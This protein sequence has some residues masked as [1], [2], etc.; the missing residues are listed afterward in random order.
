MT[1][2][3][4]PDW[5]RFNTLFLLSDT[6]NTLSP[7]VYKLLGQ[8]GMVG[9][10]SGEN[11]EEKNEPEEGEE[12]EEEQEQTA[13]KRPRRQRQVGALS[14]DSISATCFRFA[15]W[16]PAV[17]FDATC[18]RVPDPRSAPAPGSTAVLVQRH[19]DPSRY[20]DMALDIQRGGGRALLIGV[21]A[22]E[23]ASPISG[24][25]EIW[26]ARPEIL[27]IPV[28]MFDLNVIDTSS[29]DALSVSFEVE[30]TMYLDPMKV[31]SILPSTTRLENMQ[32]PIRAEKGV[33]KD[34]ALCFLQ[35][36][37]KL[38]A[39]NSSRKL[40]ITTCDE[41]TGDGES[42]P[43]MLV[44]GHVPSCLVIRHAFAC[45]CRNCRTGSGGAKV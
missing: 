26:R 36:L 10:R 15:E 2:A 8:N 37:E 45:A 7:R 12:E 14:I 21:A 40:F 39:E 29:P 4:H 30:R 34:Y 18:P 6:M 17:S 20:Y 31:N 11:N 13:V 1:S 43:H 42:D 5:G 9:S 27:H 35:I 41:E 3:R 25:E 33:I 38:H 16:A 22:E 24:M 23:L 28:V 44:G 32:L 19:D